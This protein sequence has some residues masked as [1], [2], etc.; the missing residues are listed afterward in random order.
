MAE[1]RRRCLGST[2]RRRCTYCKFTV[3]A[4]AA[5]DKTTAPTLPFTEITGGV[6]KT[7]PV[8][9]LNDVTPDTG[10]ELPGHAEKEAALFTAQVIFPS[11]VKQKVVAGGVFGAGTGHEAVVLDA[12]TENSQYVGAG[13]CA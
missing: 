5:A 6:Y 10:P 11:P 7:V 2:R 8:S 9:P 4:L 3:G 1:R 12:G 13:P